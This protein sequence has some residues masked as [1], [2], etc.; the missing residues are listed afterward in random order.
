MAA[1]DV[2][3]RDSRARS[4]IHR[5]GDR[6]SA[7]SGDLT[8]RLRR[9]AIARRCIGS[10]PHTQRRQWLIRPVAIGAVGSNVGTIGSKYRL[11][12]RNSPRPSRLVAPRR[13]AHLGV[14]NS[15]RY[16]EL[17]LPLRW[18]SAI[19][20]ERFTAGQRTPMPRCTRGKTRT[21]RSAG[22]AGQV[23]PV[24]KLWPRCG[25]RHTDTANGSR[26]NRRHAVSDSPSTSQQPFLR[27]LRRPVGV[28]VA[29]V[30]CV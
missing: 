19:P 13:H 26:H 8:Q 25:C 5:R 16:A 22:N 20:T 23:W 11:A 7:N 14:P 6:S 17:T 30:R 29:E 18:S 15:C 27:N 10:Q 3:G 2:G 4:P 24:S 1:E 12:T 9:S 21:K 28:D